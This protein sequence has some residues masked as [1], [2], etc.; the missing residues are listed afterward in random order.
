MPAGRRT[1]ADDHRAPVLLTYEEVAARLSTKPRFIRRLV[2]EHR[3]PY[4]HVGRFRRI[5]EP[6]LAAFVAAGRVEPGEGW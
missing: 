1:R 4:Y 5:A 3:I 2:A 6:D